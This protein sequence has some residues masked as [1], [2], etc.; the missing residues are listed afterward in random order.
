MAQTNSY[1][2]T[3]TKKDGTERIM[4]CTLQEEYLPETVGEVRK[5]NEDSLAVYDLDVEG[6]RSFRWDS[7]KRIN[8]T[9]GE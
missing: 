9:I 3:F 1:T 5:K 4:K 6:W 7:V 2:G 8:F